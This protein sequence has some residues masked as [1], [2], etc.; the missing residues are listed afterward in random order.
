MRVVVGGEPWKWGQV[1]RSLLV[2]VLGCWAVCPQP[3]IRGGSVVVNVIITVCYHRWGVNVGEGVWAWHLYP[4]PG[5]TRMG[6]HPQAALAWPP[7]PSLAGS[8]HDC[9]RWMSG[10]QK[11]A[12]GQCR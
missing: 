4:S 8:W 9:P 5:D 12:G 1:A 6:T 11:G 10:C 7:A 3:K 2:P